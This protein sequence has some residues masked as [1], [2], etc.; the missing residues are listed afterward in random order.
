MKLDYKKVDYQAKTYLFDSLNKGISLIF[1]VWQQID[2]F[3]PPRP[4]RRC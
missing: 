3:C 2:Y 4:E 1:K